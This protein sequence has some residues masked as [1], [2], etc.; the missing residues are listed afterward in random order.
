MRS[1]RP[2]RKRHT[3]IAT[4]TKDGFLV[5]ARHRQGVDPSQLRRLRLAY[6]PPMH[7][8]PKNLVEGRAHGQDVVVEA[9]AEDT[10]LLY[11]SLIA[12]LA[13]VLVLGQLRKSC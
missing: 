3:F 8:Q 7:V 10:R 12:D 5:V 2:V 13:R 11:F 9:H 1:I 6:R 4:S